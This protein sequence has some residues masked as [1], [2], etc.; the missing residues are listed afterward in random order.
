VE[1]AVTARA[2]E[3]VGAAERQPS[4]VVV[5]GTTGVKIYSQYNAYKSTYHYYDVWGWNGSGTL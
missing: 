3:H 4:A 2:I 1:H 5:P